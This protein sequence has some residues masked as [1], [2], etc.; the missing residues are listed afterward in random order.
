MWSRALEYQNKLRPGEEVSLARISEGF[1]E[2]GIPLSHAMRLMHFGLVELSIGQLILTSAGAHVLGVLPQP[3]WPEKRRARTVRK[4]PR[5]SS[6]QVP[7]PHG[8]RDALLL[9]QSSPR[10]PSRLRQLRVF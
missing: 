1:P 6:R 3:A 2:S 7:G 4:L 9:M 10:Q 8:D 5:E